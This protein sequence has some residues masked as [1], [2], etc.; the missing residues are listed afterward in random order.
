MI[1]KR[2]LSLLVIIFISISSFTQIN[3]V[4]TKSFFYESRSEEFEGVKWYYISVPENWEKSTGKKISLAVAV[5]NSKISSSK[6]PIVFIQGGPGGNTIEQIKF[7]I[8]HPLRES[9]DIILVDLRGT[10]YS[11]PKLCLGLGKSFLRILAKD[12]SNEQG[13]ID[14]VTVAMECKQ[15]MIDQGVDINS[16]NST[17]VAYDLHALKSALDISEWNVIGVSYG[18]YIS[19]IYANKYPEDI[20]SLV[21]DSP[22][23]DITDYYANNTYNYMLSLNKLFKSCREDSIINK[24][25]PDLENIYY[26]N[27]VMLEN[28]PITVNVDK[29]IIPTGKFTYNAEDYKIVIQQAFYSKMMIEVLPLLIYQFKKRDKHTLAGLV[30]ALSMGLSLNYGC[31]FCFTCN[32][33]IPFNDIF[34]YNSISSLNAKMHGGL[35]FYGSDFNVCKEWTK[36]D[37]LFHDSN[38]IEIDN[39]FRVLILSGWFDPITPT[40]FAEAVKNKFNNTEML[41]G[42]TYGHGLGYSVTGMNI[43]KKFVDNEIVSDS[44]LTD[45]NISKINFKTNISINKGIVRMMGDVN[46][47]QWYYFVP[48]IISL[49]VI[50]AIFIASVIHFISSKNN[51]SIINLLFFLT[52]VFILFFVI[53]IIG[54]IN[55]ILKDNFYILAFGL[56]SVFDYA[57]TLYMLS[58]VLSII[59]ILMVSI[60][61]FKRNIPLYIMIFLAISIFH[62]YFIFWGI[63]L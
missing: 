18:T 49:I 60:K 54:G 41:T 44:L 13:I 23:S 1:I 20:K 15:K 57:F 8:N 59:T 30:P 31:Y 42:Y 50:I 33:V 40:Y 51:I 3:L 62:C 29:S 53:S 9:H 16:Y 36:N 43:I 56:P 61:V 24:E 4:E 22:I 48:L 19:Q 27:I 39:S 17:S 28:D 46:S 58:F 37:S 26:S 2:I 52:S 11:E 55:S 21:L 63:V 34:R 35:S 5:L 45:F 10:G 25:Y 12:Q 6:E 38:Q 32:E 14:K 7:W 47:K